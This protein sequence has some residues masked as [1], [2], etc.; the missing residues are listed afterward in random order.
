M[1]KPQTAAERQR[2]DHETYLRPWLA[3]PRNQQLVVAL[4]PTEKTRSAKLPTQTVLR[5]ARVGGCG[6]TQA[7]I[8]VLLTFL[9][10]EG[11]AQF[12]GQYVMQCP[13]GDTVG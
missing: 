2:V 6:F 4:I 5:L 12:D 3:S 10:A 9:A 13:K 8:D 11:L 1:P 7:E